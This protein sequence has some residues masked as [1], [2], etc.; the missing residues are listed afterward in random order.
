MML[1]VMSGSAAGQ[2]ASV[3]GTVTDPLGGVLPGVTVRL[4]DASTGGVASVTTN[5]EGHFSIPAP[6]GMHLL[7]AELAGFV[8]VER[9]LRV[10]ADAQ[11]PIRLVLP[12]APRD[13]GV[14]VVGRDYRVMRTTSATRTDTP[15]IRTPQSIQV[16]NAQIIADQRPLILSDALRNVSGISSLRNSAE[17]FRSFNIRG[18]TALDM[19]V[20]GLRQTYGL[21]VQPDAV[22]HIDR[23]EV[24]KGPSA[25]LYGRGSLGGTLNVVTKSP[26]RGRA[27]TVSLSTGSGGL[28]QPTI[29]VTGAINPSGSVR[30]RAIVDYENRDT[31]ID[32]VGVERLH[33]APAIEFDVSPRTLLQVK[34]DY[35]R[36]EGLR[37]VALPAYGTV[38][39]LDDLR[40]PYDL[41]IGEPGAGPTESS[42]WQ[43][44]TRIDHAISSTW[45]LSGAARWTDVTLDMP[46]VGPRALQPDA[47]TLT[48]RYTRFDDTERELTFDG[49]ATGSVMLGGLTH[50]IVVGS[51]WSRFEY[52][53]RFSSGGVAS[54]DISRPMYGLPITGVFLLD[55]TIDRI[56]G[57]GLYL[58]DQIGIGSRADVLVGA[59]YDRVVK[60]RSYIL[61]DR[62]AARSD[63]AVS[64]RVGVSFMVRNGVALFGSYG[65]GLVGVADGTANQT[66]TPFRAQQG[67]QWE[68]G[69]KVDL[70]GG[71]VLTAAIFDLTRDGVLV[72]DPV[73]PVFQIQTG[74]QASQGLE[75]DASWQSA[76]GVS[77]IGSYTYVDAAVTRDTTIPVGNILMNVP[78]HAGRVWGKYV[79]PAASPT[80]IFAVAAGLTAQGEQQANVTNTLA[81]PASWVGDLGLFWEKGRVGAQLNVVNLFDR[82][83]AARGAFGG[84]GIIPG[85]GRRIVLTLKTML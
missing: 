64:P 2:Q 33:V 41:F 17:V 46:S 85:D 21:D 59:R 49:W 24:L 42:S 82:K 31:P 37:F 5:A 8:G 12:L 14:I 76:R 15:I 79:L 71:M 10:P 13:E 72:T 74:Q 60:R 56:S 30:A 43:T 69:V 26:Q 62:V 1:L 23:L 45:K 28:L 75:L 53:S 81:I 39:G 52:E 36:R 20:D 27:T 19:S 63:D 61:N 54:I 32:F 25:A 9:S 66:G 77:L 11:T 44:T 67:H 70:A 3:T 73:D 16:V 47:R 35:R 34:S 51:D 48:R 50:Q 68:G 65:E 38:L 57:G 7:S 83:Y 6:T 80:G 18:F 40:L 55:H 4:T 78:R 58:Q 84:T 22:A 29:D